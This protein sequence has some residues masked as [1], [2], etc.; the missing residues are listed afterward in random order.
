MG[1]IS[2]Q[3]IIEVIQINVFD[4]A[5]GQERSAKD[6]NVG[7]LTFK[8][9]TKKKDVVRENEVEQPDR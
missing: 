6:G 9:P 1:I 8:G 7:C 2:M 4:F 3:M 5:G